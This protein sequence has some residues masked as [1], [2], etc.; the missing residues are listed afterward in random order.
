MRKLRRLPWRIP[1]SHHAQPAAPVAESCP[2]DEPERQSRRD[3]LELQPVAFAGG[4][5]V[6]GDQPSVSCSTEI[7]RKV[8]H[9]MLPPL[10]I[11][12]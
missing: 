8:R 11:A 6:Y 1:K 7:R 10:A 12:G 9:R 3:L 4:R 5:Y 2:R